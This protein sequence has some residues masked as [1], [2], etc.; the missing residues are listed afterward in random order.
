MSSLSEGAPQMLECPNCRTAVRPRQ[1]F[2]GRCGATL[3]AASPARHHP[4]LCEEL[5]LLALDDESGSIPGRAGFCNL[6]LAGAIF[7]ELLLDERISVQGKRALV[8]VAPEVRFTGS[9]LLDE[10]LIRVQQSR[11]RRRLSAWV[12]SLANTRGLRE[13]IAEGLCARGVLERRESGFWVFR[14]ARFPLRDPQPEYRVVD[15]LRNAIFSDAARIDERTLALLSLASAAD[16]LSIRFARGELRARRK[17]LQRLIQDS[18]AGQAVREAIQAVQ[19]AV[20][21]CCTAA[22]AASSS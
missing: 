3:P 1:Y 14:A 16:L 20:V 4:L 22:V 18:P 11:R 2:C 17:H 5:L 6:A 21:V 12:T 7:A 10:T 19:T 9:P 15:R 13:R 8:D